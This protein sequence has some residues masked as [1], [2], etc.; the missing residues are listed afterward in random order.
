MLSCYVFCGDWEMKLPVV[1]FLCSVIA[2]WPYWNVNISESC[3]LLHVKLK[4][5]FLCT[6]IT[7][8]VAC[9]CRFVCAALL[10]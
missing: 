7:E 3:P 8:F 4:L 5:E 2:C 9:I 6:C 10:N 1:F